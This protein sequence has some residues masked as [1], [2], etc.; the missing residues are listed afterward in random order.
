MGIFALILSIISILLI[1]LA[2]IET[3]LPLTRKQGERVRMF[4]AKYCQDNGLLKEEY[5]DAIYGTEQELD[6]EVLSKSEMKKLS[7]T[8]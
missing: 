4:T 8:N 3:S 2:Y 1:V 5:L 7:K 6:K